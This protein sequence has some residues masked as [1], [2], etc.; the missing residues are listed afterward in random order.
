MIYN[1]ISVFKIQIRCKSI[2]N[3]WNMQILM[4][5]SKYIYYSYKQA[6]NSISPRLLD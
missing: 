2:K 6:G 5:K 4:Q 1:N 3:I